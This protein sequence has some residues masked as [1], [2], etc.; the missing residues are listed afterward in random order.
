MDSQS[1]HTHPKLA[2]R[3][4]VFT[5]G[6]GVK[7]HYRGHRMESAPFR[8]VVAVFE[9]PEDRGRLYAG[10][11]QLLTPTGYALYGCAHQEQRRVPGQTGFLEEWNDL[12]QELDA[13]IALVRTH[14][15][16]APLFLAGSQVTGQ[17]VM[18][19]ALHH[20]HQLQGVIAYQP[21]LH[22][23]RARRSLQSLT[24]AL[25]RVWPA[26]APTD[27]AV[28]A[29]EPDVKGKEPCFSPSA[30]AVPLSH[31]AVAEATASEI[32]IPVLI[33]DDGLPAERGAS[34]GDSQGAKS[35]STSLLEVEPWL[36][37]ILNISSA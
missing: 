35:R 22:R 31:A 34:P 24:N 8:A 25:S 2:E 33:V 15:P 6:G 28:P 13:F 7:L 10:F 32:D 17:L 12:H 26:F 30:A 3:E 37:H 21:R 29:L 4:G 27:N 11:V 5:G 23:S 18:T 20:P 19:Y 14:E 36:D 9:S 16:D 1:P